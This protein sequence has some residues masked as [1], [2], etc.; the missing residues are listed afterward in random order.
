MREHEVPTHLQAE[1]RVLLW[2]TF[3]QIVAVIAVCALA[4]GVYRY[5]LGPS[6]LRIAL[7]VFVGVLGIVSIVGRIGGRGL[8]AVLADLLRFRLAP[9]RYSG[10]VAD[11][12]RG[13]APFQPHR[14][15]RQLKM[16]ATIGRRA[17][18][19]LRRKKGKEERKRGR[20]P[21]RPHRWFGERKKG[22]KDE[23]GREAK[24]RRRPWRLTV[25]LAVMSAL[26][27]MPAPV[28]AEEDWLAEIDYRPP[29]Q[30]PGRRLFVEELQVSG[31]SARVTLRAAADL[32]LWSR[33]DGGVQGI[34]MLFSGFSR[35][36]QGESV[37]YDLPLSGG[38]P[39]LTFSWE[40]GL[41]QAGALSFEGDRLPYPLPSVEGEVC[42]LRVTSLGWRPGVVEGSLES[43]CVTEL[44]ERM[45]LQTVSGHESVTETAVMEAT[46]TAKSG[47]V[48]AN[49]GGNSTTT[50]FVPDGETALSVPVSGDGVIH[51]I[52]L[53][54]RVQAAVEVEVPPLVRLTHRP[55]RTEKRTQ[56]VSLLRP[57]T[58]ETVSE[59]VDFEHCD[60]TFSRET[61]SATLSIPE[62]TVQQDVVLT[63]VHPE[64]VS[65]EVEDRDPQVRSRSET[66]PMALSVGS[67]EPFKTLELPEQEDEPDPAEQTP[68]T[69]DE[70]SDLLDYALGLIRWRPW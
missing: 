16:A 35:L 25:A 18:R 4:Y 58:S 9:R 53:E 6:E 32:D 40:D 56:T 66:L 49:V 20:I 22:P 15:S 7:A 24:K 13:E 55:E 3:P 19:R 61:I 30:V 41:G 69:D 27:L 28:L 43:E 21:F 44:E 45:S 29:E 48:T 67:D 38:S 70:A 33:S 64:H 11:L 17:L 5:A 34:Q 26:L 51:F 46:V 47:S 59:T 10:A 14:E 23:G 37:V 57:G 1:D 2:F 8:P 52:S 54:T 36:E 68:L 65:A 12:V 62:A 50:P 63:I 60:G 42:D 31:D 39:S